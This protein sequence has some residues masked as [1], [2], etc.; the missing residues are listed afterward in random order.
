M[1]PDTTSFFATPA[2]F[3]EWIKLIGGILGVIGGLTALVVTYSSKFLPWWRKWRSVI[4]LEKGLSADLYSRGIIENAIRYYIEPFC[5]SLDPAGADEPRLLLGTQENLFDTID[6]ALNHPTE[7]RYIFLLADSGMGKSSFM[8]NYY[9]RNLHKRKRKFEIALFPLGVPKIDERINGIKSK[10]RKKTVLFLD[11][12]DE[13]TLA[14]VDHVARLVDLLELTSDFKKIVITC[15]TQFF[16]KDEEIP[17]E[18]G[19]IKVGPRAAGEK[20]QYQFHKLYLSPFTSEQVRQY[21]KNLYPFWY[22]KR[23]NKAQQMVEKIPNL[24]IRPM[25]LAHINDLIKEEQEITKSYQLYEEMVDAWLVREEG[26]LENIQKE[27]LRQF[28]EHLAVD[29]YVNRQRR[30]SERVPRDELT[31]LAHQWNIP[32][33]DWQLTGRSLLNRDAMGNYKFAHRSIMEYLFVKRFMEGEQACRNIPWSDQMQAFLWE[34]I[35]EYR[36]KKDSVPFDLTGADLSLFPL[37][38]RPDELNLLEGKNVKEMLRHYNFFCKEDDWSKL[39]SNPVGKG[40]KHDYHKIK[41]GKA[42]LDKTTNLIWQKSGSPKNM[43]YKEAKNYIAQLNRK[44]FVG[45]ND[46]RL[47]T[48]EEAMSLMEP[49]QKIGGLYIDPSFDEAQRYIWTS[50]LP[51]ASHVWVVSFSSGSCG[52]VKINTS[53][54]VR[55]VRS[56]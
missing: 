49:D 11:A 5:Q 51:N 52:Y 36:E 15:R 32:I 54:Y 21:L 43:K 13:D 37:L 56:D 25:L 16:P 23:R 12:F 47:P 1:P 42:V 24:S 22:H 3:A 19:I 34:I 44:R 18:T 8:I 48:L 26:I 10:H 40:I 41:Y 55:A 35:Q 33:D 29:V 39:W 20:A 27:P 6:R 46:W 50:D 4:S 14:I 7:Y 30:G 2:D 28:C 17:R 45:Y 53:N 38:L 31:E 9:A